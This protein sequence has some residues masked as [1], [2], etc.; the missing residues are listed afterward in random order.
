[1]LTLVRLGWGQEGDLAF[2]QLF[3]SQFIPGGTKEQADWFNALQQ[4][5]MLARRRGAQLD[6]NRRHR[7]R[8]RCYRRLSPLLLSCMHETMLAYRSIKVGGSPQEFPERDSCRSR[9][10]ITSFLKMS[11]PSPDFYRKSGHS[12]LN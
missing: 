2:R 5:V 4:D 7:C 10:A 3:T 12:F 11:P 6:R 8:G 1:M 9:A